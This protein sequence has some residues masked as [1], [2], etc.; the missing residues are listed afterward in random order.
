M[1]GGD[2]MEYTVD[3]VWDE[4]AQV[5]IATSQDVPGL[6]TESDSYDSLIENLK[7]LIPELLELN[8]R[9]KMTALKCISVKQQVYSFG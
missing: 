5:W 1:F 3:I 4:E 7:S 2:W 6:V 8:H 9:P